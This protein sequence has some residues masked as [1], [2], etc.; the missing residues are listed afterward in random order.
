MIVFRLADKRYVDDREGVGAKL[1]G[2]RW[3]EVNTPCIYT[4]EHIS[5]ALLEKFVH[6]RGSDSMKNIG[7]LKITIPDDEAVLFNVDVN[8]LEDEWA[9]N[10]SYTQW[11]GGQLLNDPATL[12]FSVPSAIIPDEKNVILNPRSKY[13][14][15]ITFGKIIDFTTDY[16]LLNMLLYSS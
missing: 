7:L 14:S 11:I 5:L 13:F 4:S 12:A 9:E 2:G 1:F 3:N 16:R 6:A 10:I 15:R 8:R